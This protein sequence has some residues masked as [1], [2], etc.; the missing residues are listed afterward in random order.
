MGTRSAAARDLTSA[1]LDRS[2]V[3]RCRPMLRPL[4]TP[5]SP[6]WEKT[7]SIDVL[8]GAGERQRRGSPQ[9]ERDHACAVMSTTHG[10]IPRAP[11]SLL[12]HNGH[13]ALEST[14]RVM[15]THSVPTQET[16][17]TRSYG[18][19]RR[20][21]AR[22]RRPGR[23]FCQNTACAAVKR[24]FWVILVVNH[25]KERSP[26]HT[27]QAALRRARSASRRCRNANSKKV[28]KSHAEHARMRP[29]IHRS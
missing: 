27:T 26:V 1:S 3:D 2:S 20:S 9:D 28:V 21:T 10:R 8:S 6:A 22:G 19:R 5:A 29:E 18:G 17:I 16:V 4:S 13:Q 14:S 23:T 25:C 11:S 7:F 24:K 15:Q 12:H